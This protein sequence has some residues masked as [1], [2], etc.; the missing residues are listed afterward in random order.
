MIQDNFSWCSSLSN[1][2]T[3]KRNTSL[4]LELDISKAFDSIT[5]P[6][7]LEVLHHRG[8]GY[9]CINLIATIL[10]TSSS[11]VLINGNPSSPIAHACGLLQGDPISPMLFLLVIDILDSIFRRFNQSQALLPVNQ[12]RI[13]HR[14]SFFADDVALFLHPTTSDMATSRRLLELFG[15][16]SGLRVNLAKSVVVPIR[17]QDLDLTPLLV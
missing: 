4:F 8:F 10:R 7:L 9:K 14:A 11:K 6:F 16:A 13:K 3:G 1:S 15:G 5:W 17:C 12:W 2:S